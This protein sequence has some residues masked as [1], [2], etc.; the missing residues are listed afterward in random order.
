MQAFELGNARGMDHLNNALITLLPKKVGASCPSDFRPIMM[1]HSF[2]KLISKMLSLR[3]APSLPELVSRNQNAFIRARS[4]HDNYKYVQRA[5]MLIREKKIPMLLLKL[6]ISKAFNTLSWPF[7]L[8][9]LQAHGFS[10]RWCTWVE[11]L[12]STASL[13]IVLNRHQGPSIRHLRGVRQGDS[14]SPM[15]FIIAMDVLHRLFHKVAHDGVL[16]NMAPPKIKSICRRR[17][18]LHSAIN[19]GG[20]SNQGNTKHFRSSDRAAHKPRQVLSHRHLRRLGDSTENCVHPRLLG[21][22][23]PD[24]V[25]GAAT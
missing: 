25:S 4:I 21:S 15:L 10:G 16:K 12:L 14:L 1:I 7:L 2:A 9:V 5:A 11:T 23:F 18:P 3:L 20:N 8:E 17:H 19:P 22:T 6:D 13:R 24:Q